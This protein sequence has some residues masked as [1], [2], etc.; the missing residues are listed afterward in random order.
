M[1]GR[2]AVTIC[3][4][5]RLRSPH[6][7]RQWL[8]PYKAEVTGSIPFVEPRGRSPALPYCPA[9]RHASTIDQSQRASRIT[10]GT[11][12]AAPG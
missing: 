9:A 3:C 12:S 7:E 2:E 8:N 5:N 6:Q 1:A 11:V 4:G 10:V